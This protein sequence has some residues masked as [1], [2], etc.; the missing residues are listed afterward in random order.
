ME[1]PLQI[2]HHIINNMSNV[3]QFQV[4]L[5]ATNHVKR[6]LKAVVRAALHVILDMYCILIHA[7]TI[8]HPLPIF[9]LVYLTLQPNDNL[10]QL[11]ICYSGN[12]GIVRI[13]VR[14]A[15]AP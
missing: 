12:A 13:H 11:M 10:Q 1:T 15:K 5:H 2:L 4:K 7:R 3:S 8:A 9:Y 6:V 14:H